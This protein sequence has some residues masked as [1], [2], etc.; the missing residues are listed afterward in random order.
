MENVDTDKIMENQISANHYSQFEDEGRE[1]LK[2]KG[3]I[4][5]KKDGSDLTKEK[6]I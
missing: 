3:I 2:F 4:D 5:R 1:I 6:K